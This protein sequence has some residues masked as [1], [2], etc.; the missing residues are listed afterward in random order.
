MTS[1]GA[2]IISERN[3]MPTFKVQGQVYHLI[4]SLL[5]EKDKTSKFLQIYFISDYNEPANV[6]LRNF[7]HLNK[8]LIVDLQSCLHQVNPY[9]RDFKIALESIPINKRDNYNLIINADRKPASAHS[10]C[11]NKPST[12][13]VAVLLVDQHYE[14]RDIVLSTKN[15]FLKRICETHRSYDALQYPLIFCRGEKMVI[16]LV[17]KQ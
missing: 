3:F 6:R 7:K 5:P 15:G 2:K 13:E 14:R 1:F 17:F 10:G 16:I 11:Y 9:V 8:D 12:N 4:G